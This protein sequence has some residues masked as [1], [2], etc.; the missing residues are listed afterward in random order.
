M[1]ARHGQ[2]ECA[3]PK[4]TLR[5]LAPAAIDEADR[6]FVTSAGFDLAPLRASVQ[7]LGVLNPPLV[8]QRPDG[9]SQIITGWQ[10]FLVAQELSL[11]ELPVLLVPAATP[12]PWCLL[13]SLHDNALGRGFNPLEA[14]N[15]MQRLLAY[16]P[17]DTVRREHLPALGLPPSASVLQ[18]HLD[19]LTLE[20]PWQ[21]L[22]ARRRLT[23]AAA[24]RLRN[25]P[26]PDRQALLPWFQTLTLSHSKQLEFLEYLTTL[27]R[28]HGTSPAAW[29]HQPE[30][31]GILADPVLAPAAKD[32]QLWET[33]RRWCFPRL[34]QA[35]Q[36]AQE[37]LKALGLWQHP[38]I[39]LQSSPA[40]ED[41]TW[42]LELR[43][44]DPIQLA[45]QLR[46][47]Q[48]LLDRPELAALCRL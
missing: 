32:R 16:F 18:N 47:I 8:R 30:L 5:R 43:F 41:A 23:V 2:V 34:S 40:F 36:A 35:R 4:A 6:T 13:A 19:L 45:D 25:W 11:P 3:K 21:Q 44:T 27:S 33:L 22:A 48:N 46:Q 39:R 12:P 17:A 20:E 26:T 1:P 28:R 15:M 42:R 29:L 9:R 10:R 24:A 14:A 38:L 7:A 37:N 31:A